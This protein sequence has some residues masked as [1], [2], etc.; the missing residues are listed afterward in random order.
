M[1]EVGIEAEF[2]I[3][4]PSLRYRRL[5]ND[6]PRCYETSEITCFGA[7]YK[8][9]VLGHKDGTVDIFDHLGH[10]IQNGSYRRVVFIKRS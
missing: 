5:E 10:R 6:C 2:A 7:H 4:E 9:I 8:F 3:E 1:A